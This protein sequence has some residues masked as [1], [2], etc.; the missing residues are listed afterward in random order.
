M[1]GFRASAGLRHICPNLLRVSPVAHPSLWFSFPVKIS[2]N[3]CQ[4]HGSICASGS[5]PEGTDPCGARNGLQMVIASG[6]SRQGSFTHKMTTVLAGVC[7]TQVPE[8]TLSQ[9][10]KQMRVIPQNTI[11]LLMFIIIPSMPRFLVCKAVIS[12][13]PALPSRPARR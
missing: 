10:S 7:H 2:T 6:A 4:N 1:V 13:G 12:D 9:Y 11:S 5:L 8:T 3:R